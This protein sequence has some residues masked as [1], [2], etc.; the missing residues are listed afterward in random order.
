MDPFLAIETNDFEA[1]KAFKKQDLAIELNN[2]YGYSPLEWAYLLGNKKAAALLDP[3]T[4]RNLKIDLGEGVKKIAPSEFY[5]F[6]EAYHYPH[7]QFDSLKSLQ[8]KLGEAP[9]WIA[10]TP[11]GYTLR[12]EGKKYRQEIASGYVADTVIR[13]IDEEI[14]YGLFAGKDILEGEYIAEYTG[15]VR[16]IDLLHKD[17][18]SYCFHYPTRWWAKN[19]TVID[20]LRQGNETRFINHSSHPNIEPRW[21]YDRGLMHLVFFASKFIPKGTQLTFNY[22]KDFW[23]TRPGEVRQI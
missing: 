22:G 6:V 5:H 15:E 21:L 18:N 2:S 11:V 9:I 13:W 4:P 20:A 19:Y 1:I 7:L 14:G 17:L 12:K 23:K 10:Y 8:K 3:R 16:E